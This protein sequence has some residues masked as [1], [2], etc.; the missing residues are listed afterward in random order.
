VRI[1]LASDAW[2]ERHA[3]AGLPG[4]LDVIEQD[5]TGVLHPDLS[6]AIRSALR[7]GRRV[8]VERAAGF[9]WH[10]ATAQFLAGLAPIPLALRATLAVSRSSAMIA[11]IAAR[12]QTSEAG[13]AN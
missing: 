13:D 7:L 2:P 6:E 10:A 3:L 11:R 12:R 4:P 9:S 1:A 8:C 5:V